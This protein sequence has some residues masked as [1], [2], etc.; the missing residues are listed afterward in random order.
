MKRLN[1]LLENKF[2]KNIMMVASGTAFAQILTIALSPIITRIYPPEEY[3]ILSVYVSLITLLCI[4]ASL[5]YQKAIPIAQDDKDAYN[6]IILA[7]FILLNFIIV[8]SLLLV[9]W[10]EQLISL[11]NSKSLVDYMYFI[12][13]GVLF[14]GGY[15]II[16]NWSLRVKDFQTIT[17]TSVTQSIVSNFSKIC[18]GLIG[19]GPPGLILGQIIG[20][21]GGIS[22]L[23]S[24]LIRKRREFVK[25]IKMKEII[26][27]SNRYI[28]FPLYS[29][30]SNY[31]YTA[32][33]H[34]PVIIITALFGTVAAGLYGLANS[35]V[36][37]PISL[38]AN[39][40]SQVF[41]SEVA[42]I[43]KKNP[44]KIKK[45]LLKISGKLAIIGLIP[46]L[47]FV[48]FGPWVFSIIFGQYWYDAGVY[49]RV[50]AFVAY[51]HFI[52]FPAGRIL[53]VV[54]KQNIG[55][56]VNII[57]LIVIIIGFLISYL[58]EFTALQ[59]VMIYSLISTLS[60]LV[61][62]IVVQKVLS[63]ETGLVE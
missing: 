38:L 60:Y 41:Y 8:I 16:L 15:N 17:K 31:V 24:P 5:D 22:R 52:I 36:N 2:V 39:S 57:R 11:L 7:F 63:K 42:S 3:G 49:A 9:C 48:L 45:L 54:E 56:F 61:L 13:L 35:I 34:A 18:L 40:I 19:L 50:L 44:N 10:G 29:A 1:K 37:L 55:L 58:F 26:K 33:G 25:A 20:Q 6:L 59:T 4:G 23:S 46:L 12:P 21:S 27:L 28:K 53:E 14:I 43:G 32:G 62:F 30:P 51:A 47:V